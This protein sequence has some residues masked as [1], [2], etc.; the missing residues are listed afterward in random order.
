MLLVAVGAPSCLGGR[1][2]TH[3]VR[4]RHG[5]LIKSADLFFCVGPCCLFVPVCFLSRMP[6]M[7]KRENKRS[8]SS[9]F[10]LLPSKEIIS[11]CEM[12][13]RKKRMELSFFTS[14]QPATMSLRRLPG[15]QNGFRH[16]ATH[17]VA[18]DNWTSRVL[19]LFPQPPEPSGWSNSLLA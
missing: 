12:T 11:A 6:L 19:S 3:L 7:E 16:L 1:D 8:S 9:S 13:S 4:D 17:R 5:N 14:Y 18:A 10:L 15:R 2:K